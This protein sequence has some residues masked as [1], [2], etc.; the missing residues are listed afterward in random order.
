MKLKRNRSVVGLKYIKRII[1]K[2][3]DLANYF[4]NELLQEKDGEND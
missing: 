1:D 3:I 4:F 2:N